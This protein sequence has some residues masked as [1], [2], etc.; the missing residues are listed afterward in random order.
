MSTC[1]AKAEDSS[2]YPK[3][4]LAASPDRLNVTC[5]G[6]TMPIKAS[7]ARTLPMSAAARMA[8]PLRPKG[9]LQLAIRGG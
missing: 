2:P 3:A 7:S 8:A 9:P 6:A 5:S 1:P 4:A